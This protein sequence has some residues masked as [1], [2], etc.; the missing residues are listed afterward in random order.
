MAAAMTSMAPKCAA[1]AVRFV[2]GEIEVEEQSVGEWGFGG[3]I[4]EE[5]PDDVD[6]GEHDGH[7]VAAVSPVEEPGQ[8]GRQ[9][10]DVMRGRENQVGHEEEQIAD[11]GQ[12]NHHGKP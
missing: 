9:P 12:P 3:A 11:R 5:R 2:R 1:F 6:G 7:G 10:V 8:Q 4:Q